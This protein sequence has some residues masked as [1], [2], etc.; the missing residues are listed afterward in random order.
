LTLPTA[1]LAASTDWRHA[2][3]ALPR[4]SEDVRVL[5]CLL[6][7]ARATYRAIA[8]VAVQQLSD[9]QRTIDRQR[10][11]IAALREDY[12]QA[13]DRYGRELASLRARIL[14]LETI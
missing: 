12:T 4:E 7:D 5:V 11:T 8:S 6:I 10:D 2:V 3:T 9:A 14:M 1:V 13:T